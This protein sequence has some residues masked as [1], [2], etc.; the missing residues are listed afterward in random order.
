[1][2]NMMVVHINGE[3]KIE[4]DRD[5][6]IT[7]LQKKY[8][9]KMDEQMDQGLKL[10]D[11]FIEQPD[12]KQRAQ[13][14]AISLI[15]AILDDQESHIAATCSYLAIRMPDLKQVK[16]QIDNAGATIELIFDEVFE[17]PNKNQVKVSFS[18]PQKNNK[19]LH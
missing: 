4:Y 13:F 10:A 15:E 7:D 9:D 17:M 2:S 5:V 6:S 11:Q 3:S 18:P 8:L 1:M 14:V 19:A 12:P 16:C